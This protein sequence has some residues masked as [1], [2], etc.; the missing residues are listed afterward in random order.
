MS[1]R[2][3]ETS[4]DLGQGHRYGVQIDCLA[5]HSPVLLCDVDLN[6]SGIIL[7]VYCG[8]AFVKL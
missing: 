8:D 6:K 1:L 5:H 3:S 2:G 7:D 4:Q